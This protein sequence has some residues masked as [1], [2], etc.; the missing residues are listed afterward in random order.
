MPP[1]VCDA[2]ILIAAFIPEDHSDLAEEFVGRIRSGLPVKMPQH[3][4]AEVGHTLRKELVRKRIA[5]DVL[6]DLWADYR[7]LEIEYVDI[8]GVA[9]RALELSIANMASYYDSLY[10]ALAIRD[11]V[12]F[13]T[14]D[15]R[16][17]KAFNRVA[18]V[19]I[20]LRDYL[21]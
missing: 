6:Q 17:V 10:A 12:P 2:S 16:T 11:G 21:A 4:L 15:D 1:V 13:I 20:N 14:L 3:A 19:V 5:P 18:G 9:D 8:V 7:S